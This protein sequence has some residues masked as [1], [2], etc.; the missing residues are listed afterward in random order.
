MDLSI[1]S[2]YYHGLIILYLV[3][4]I[5]SLLAFRTCRL[6]SCPH[7]LILLPA[8]T[9]VKRIPIGICYRPVGLCF[10]EN[11]KWINNSVLHIEKDRSVYCFSQTPTANR[12]GLKNRVAEPKLIF[13]APAPTPAP[14]PALTFKKFP[15][16]LRSSDLSFEGACFHSF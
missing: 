1:K 6:M 3:I 10:E 13:S 7:I 4:H 5:F 16:R 12:T 2:K 15:L 9:V 8:C 11:L 14:A